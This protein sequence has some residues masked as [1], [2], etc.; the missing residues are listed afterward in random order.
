MKLGDKYKVIDY[1]VCKLV[2][3]FETENGELV[4]FDDAVTQGDV[5]EQVD[6]DD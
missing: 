1:G 2:M 3:A 6:A 4:S 5:G